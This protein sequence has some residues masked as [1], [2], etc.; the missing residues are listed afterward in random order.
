MTTIL[1]SPF[2]ILS[3]FLG[4][5]SSGNSRT[6]FI[7]QF[8]PSEECKEDGCVHLPDSFG[9]GKPFFLYASPEVDANAS[10]CQVAMIAAKAREL[11]GRNP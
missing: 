9:I 5:N 11:C 3:P 6:S 1:R 10:I 4:G 8:K 2:N 7:E